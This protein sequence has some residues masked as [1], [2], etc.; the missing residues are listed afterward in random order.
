MV[1]GRLR[2]VADSGEVVRLHGFLLQISDFAFHPSTTASYHGLSEPLIHSA[3][4][5]VSR[6]VSALA[7]LW[8]FDTHAFTLL[9]CSLS[10]C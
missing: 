4:D 5:L 10:P 6:S 2:A 8:A 9:K 3:Y 7:F 1:W